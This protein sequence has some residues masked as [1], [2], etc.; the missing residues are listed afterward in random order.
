MQ[1]DKFN[2]L[3]SDLLKEQH[4]CMSGM[5]LASKPFDF[6]ISRMVMNIRSGILMRC[7]EPLSAHQVYT[8]LGIP[9]QILLDVTRR[10]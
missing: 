2:E 9:D 1:E 10:N 3:Y 8:L 6:W 4:K 5:D 7:N